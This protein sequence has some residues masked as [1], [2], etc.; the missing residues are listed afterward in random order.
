[1]A[2]KLNLKKLGNAR[3][4]RMSET[5]RM[6]LS[7]QP[8]LQQYFNGR[9]EQLAAKYEAD[10]TPCRVKIAVVPTYNEKIYNIVTEVI[11]ADAKTS[12][13]IFRVTRYIRFK[14]WLESVALTAM[15]LE[16][17]VEE[18]NI[19]LLQSQLPDNIAHHFVN[20]TRKEEDGSITEVQLRIE[21]SYAL[22]WIDE[23]LKAAT[24]EF[25]RIGDAERTRLT[26]GQ[27]QAVPVFVRAHYDPE[28][29][30]KVVALRRVGPF[31]I[32][33]TEVIRE[34]GELLEIGIVKDEDRFEN[35]SQYEQ[36]EITR[37]LQP[38]FDGAF[39]WTIVDLGLK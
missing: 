19:N 8:V 35:R 24:E 4:H 39:P 37:F 32:G 2:K 20:V 5:E 33:K 16:K 9:A 27:R 14:E 34:I 29:S 1:M 22:A 28:V 26:L 12:A 17:P 13:D 30:T 10:G 23:R 38:L 11:P 6:F 31:G 25:N 18:Q 3:K 7:Q 21:T 15:E 36:A